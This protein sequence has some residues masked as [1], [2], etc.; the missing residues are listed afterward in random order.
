MKILIDRIE[1]KVW[2]Y[3]TKYFGHDIHYISKNVV[4]DKWAFVSYIPEACY[5]K[6]ESFLNGHQSRREMKTIVKVFKSL[7]YN[8]YVGDYRNTRLPSIN[9]S[10]IFGLEPAFEKACNR[11]PNALKIYYATGASYMHQNGM[12]KN[13]TDEFN[14]R[15][16][17]IVSYPYQRLAPES[18]RYYIA[19]YIIQIGS[20]YTIGTY[21]EILRSKIKKIRQSSTLVSSDDLQISLE[22]K[23][24]NTFLSLV[25]AGPVL[26]GVDLIVEYFRNHPEYTLHLAGSVDSDFWK[27]VGGGIP[28][29][30]YHGFINTS[31]DEFKK[32]AEKCMFMLYPSC[33][34]GG[35]PGSVINSMYYGC[36]PLVTKWAASSIEPVNQYGFLIRGLKVEDIAEAVSKARLLNDSQLLELC[37]KDR[38]YV[39]SNYNLKNFAKDLTQALKSII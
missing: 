36:I 27:A 34:E 7:G 38:N 37:M 1:N 15:Y 24:K 6:G 11:W 39:I 31:S 12:I 13:R 5:R 21:P 2:Y 14:M 33:T 17:P 22:H 8:V 25:G 18:D 19:D 23:D 26:K 20:D 9:P 3:I 4:K 10:I 28:N 35:M 16:K 29:V 32:I 30:I